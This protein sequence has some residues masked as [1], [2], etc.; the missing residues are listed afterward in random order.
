MN[1]IIL[2]LVE[3]YYQIKKVTKSNAV[4]KVHTYSNGYCGQ[5]EEIHRKCVW[6][7]S[8][9]NNNALSYINS[10][11][12]LYLFLLYPVEMKVQR[13]RKEKK[14]RVTAT[15]V[16]KYRGV[17]CGKSAHLREGVTS[18]HTS[19]LRFSDLTRRFAQAS[20]CLLQS[21]NKRQQKKSKC[22]TTLVTSAFCF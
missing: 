19:H 15:C 20:S 3:Y 7:D 10:F 5:I 18:K 17:G 21:I 22:D 1:I 12:P 2:P 13:E 16:N 4:S 11:I 8:E 9:K 6:V 14:E